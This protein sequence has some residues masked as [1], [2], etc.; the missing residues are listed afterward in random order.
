M[1]KL[2]KPNDNSKEVFLE[3]I[4]NIRKREFKERLE[5]CA[6]E[7]ADAINDYDDKKNNNRLHRIHSADSISGIVS[8][9][10]MKRL[11]N[12][13]FV[14]K[15]GPGRKYYDKLISSAKNGVCPICGHREVST[16]D[17]YLSKM[18]YPLFAVA[19]INLIPA[20]KDCN[21]TKG[22]YEFNDEK[23][24]TLHPY[25]DEIDNVIWLNA[26]LNEGNDIVFIFEVLRP[27]E[28]NDLL[29]ERVKNHFK[30][31][32]L[33]KLY[34][35]QAVVE[36]EGIKRMLIKMYQRSGGEEVRNYLEECLESYEY[37]NLNS[38]KCGMYR[39]LIKSDWFYDAWLKRY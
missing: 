10:E 20:C 16:L 24:A 30:T 2:P 4:S 26:K 5:L 15:K 14:G 37:V 17:H 33:N 19:L 23:H 7:I 28:W 21:F 3:C 29:Y 34:S 12:N 1:R 25:Y 32:N 36:F 8:N 38:W 35:V 39:A 18:K 31:F 9:E 13:K 6:D 11:Y 27:E 22:E